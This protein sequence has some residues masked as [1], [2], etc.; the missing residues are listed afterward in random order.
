MSESTLELR[1]WRWQRRSALLLLPLVAF[2]VYFQYFVVGIDGVDFSSTAA[3][4]GGG[5]L[6]VIDVLLL[7]TALAH[8]F[9]GL[10][11]IAIDYARSSGMARG[12]TVGLSV[13]LAAGIL[14]GLATIFALR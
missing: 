5:L 11:S 12:V 4:L 7:V 6:L 1:L 3:R 9:L 10:R 14:Y 2:H 13:V 8:G